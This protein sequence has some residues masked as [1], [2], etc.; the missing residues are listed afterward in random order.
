LESRGLIKEAHGLDVVSN[1]LESLSMR[2]GPAKL[3]SMY[4]LPA[5]PGLDESLLK[6]ISQVA[7]D[8]G[9]KEVDLGDAEGVSLRA[10]APKSENKG[11]RLLIVSGIHGDENATPFG[12]LYYLT[13]VD[14]HTL[15]KVNLTFVPLA[16]P[17]GFRK[18]LRENMWEEKTNRNYFDESK[19]SREGRILKSQRDLLKKA[20]GHGM[21][22]MHEDMDSK[23]CYV[24]TTHD[25][26]AKRLSESMIRTNTMFFKA[27]PKYDI[28]WAE[29]DKSFEDWMEKEGVSEIIVTE[30]P[31]KEDFDARVHANA[32]LINSFV[33]FH[34]A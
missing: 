10:L 28:I 30:T 8:K 17:T 15:G 26:N 5:S 9:F 11:P 13:H 14:E 21:L 31:G 29:H 33:E 12:V 27:S 18:G 19:I 7:A 16:N 32:M 2:P 4:K 3:K 1:T 22:S 23:T 20:C 25:K 34:I 24:Y 6:K